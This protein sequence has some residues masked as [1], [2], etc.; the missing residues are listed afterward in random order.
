MNKHLAQYMAKPITSQWCYHLYLSNSVCGIFEYFLYVKISRKYKNESA[1]EKH[2]P[3]E[4]DIFET[5]MERLGV[6]S[7]KRQISNPHWMFTE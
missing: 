1:F 5:W 3:Y 6:P 7:Q 2:G 4:H